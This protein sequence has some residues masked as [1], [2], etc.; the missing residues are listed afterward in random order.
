MSTTKLLELE[1]KYAETPRNPFS[2]ELA[3]R[4]R[5]NFKRGKPIR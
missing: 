2:F 3:R 1:R 4:A 5:K